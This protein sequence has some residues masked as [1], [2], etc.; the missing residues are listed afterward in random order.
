MHRR[1]F[2]SAASAL[3]F[4]GA[5][6]AAPGKQEKYAGP[7]PPR[8]KWK[9]SFPMPVG[10]ALTAF[11]L[12]LRGPRDVVVFANG[13]MVVV[14]P[15]LDDAA[16]EASAK[17]HLKGIIGF[18]PDMAPRRTDAGDVLV[19]YNRDGYE[20]AFNL[21]LESV[22]RAHW[23]EIEDRHMD[24]LTPDE[25]LI[26]PR[27]PNKFDEMGKMALLGRAYMFLDALD[28]KVVRIDRSAK[29]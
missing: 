28:P 23:D 18:H 27:G 6:C 19:S 25:I 5:G 11:K 22:A 29:T 15:G 20:A 14:R 3:L 9:P 12:A 1:S 4:L 16:A 2:I 24:G 10:A 13:T 26:T 21:V 7:W 8:P 17:T